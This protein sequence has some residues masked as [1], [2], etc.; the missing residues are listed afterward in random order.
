MRQFTPNILFPLLLVFSLG[1]WISL[2][3]PHTEI[4]FPFETDA[5]PEDTIVK[6]KRKKTQPNYVPEDRMGDPYAN[7]EKSSMQLKDPD[8]IQK[9]VELDPSLEHYNVNEKVGD[10]DYRAPSEVSFEEFYKMKNQEMLKN[11]WKNK[12][13]VE[14]SD[15]PNKEKGPFSL[16][17]PVRGLEGPFGSNFVDIRPTGLV[18]LDFGGKWQRVYNPALTVRQQK[19]GVFDFDQQITMNVVGKIGEK[20]KITANWDTKAAFEFQNNVK[21]QYTAFE[22][23][24]IQG[25]EVGRVS[26][27]LNSTLINGAQ[28]LFGVKTKL[29]FGR[30]T[31][32]S[33]FARQDGKVDEMVI[34]GGSQGR[35]FEVKGHNYEDYRH[36]FLS[37][38]F[39]ENFE[40]SLESL[41]VMNSG[42]KVTRVE[43]YVTN[44]SST[45]TDLRDMISYLDL[46]E[47]R[48]Y[49]AAYTNI[50]PPPPLPTLVPAQNTAN[51]L[52]KD[53]GNFRNSDAIVT[54][55]T[56][57]GLVNGTD[58]ALIKSARKLTDK[59]FTFHPDLGYISLQTPIRSDEVLAVSFEYSYQGK[60]YKVG[61][62]NEDYQGLPA[63][64]VVILKML[65]PYTIKLDLPT[66][67]LMMKNIYNIGATQL[68]RDNFQLRVIYKDD[69]SGVDLPNLQEGV[70]TKDK[71]LLQ[72]MG[73]DRL[74]PNNDPAPDGNFDYVEGVT[75]DSRNGRI[76]FPKLQPFGSNLDSQFTPNEQDLRIKYVF[77]ELYSSTK[78][79]AEQQASRNKFFLKGRYQASSSSEIILPGINIAPGSVVVIVG[80]NQLTEGTDYTI[81]YT[82]GRLKIINEGAL[83]SGQEI[84]IRF[85]KQDLFNFRRKSFYGGRFDYQINKDFVIGGT[86]LQQNEAPQITRVNVGDEPSKNTVWGVD[87][88]YTKDSRIITKAVDKIPFID[89]KAPSNVSFQGE[90]AQML[91]GHNKRI[92]QDGSDGV[93]FIDDFEGSK[94]PYDVSK[95]PTKWKLAATPRRFIESDSNSLA[96]SYRKA[97]FAWYNI[98]NV[99]YRNNNGISGYD[100]PS[101][102][103]NHFER[104]IFPQE[105]Y[106]NQD[107]QQVNINLTTFDLSF[108][109][110]ERGPYNF[111]PNLNSN[112]RL[113]NPTQNWGGVSRNITSDIDFDNANIQYIEFWMM[114]PY[115]NFPNPPSNVANTQIEGIPFNQTNKGKL[116]FNLGDISEDIMNDGKQSYENGLPISEALVASESEETTWGRVSKKQFL[117]DAFNN[118]PEARSKQDVGLDG[119]GNSGETSFF[120]NYVQSIQ[121]SPINPTVKDSILKD[122][123]ADDFKYYLGDDQNGKNIVQRYKNF[124]GVDNNSPVNSGGSFTPSNSSLPDNEDLN[125][126][127]TINSLEEYYEYEVNIDPTKFLVGQ[128]FIVSTRDS[129]I[130]G[131][132]VTWYQFRIPVRSPTST[133]GNIDGYKSI[134]FMRMYMSGFTSPIILRTA[135]MQLVANQWRGYQSDDINESG[136]GN[137]AEPDDALIDVST[138]NVEENGQGDNATSPYVVPPGFSRDQDVTSTVNRRL[139]EQSLRLCVTDLDD[140]NARAVYKNVSY[141]FMNYGKVNMFI[142][143]ES[144]DP[145]LTDGKVSAFLRL[146]TDFKDNYYEI[147]VPLYLTNPKNTN[148]PNLI[149]R[150]ENTI[151][152]AITELVNTKLE[153]DRAGTPVTG[154]YSRIFEGKKLTVVGKP[155]LSAVVTIMIGLKNPG[156]DNMPHSFC[157]WANELRVTD[158]NEKSGWAATGKLNVKLADFGNVTA[159]GRFIGAGFGSLEQKVSQRQR[160]NLLEWG[161]AGNFSLDKFLPKKIGLKLPMYVGYNR[162]V[163]TPRYDPLSPD[164]LLKDRLDNL[165]SGTSQ[166]EYKNLVLDQSTT[167]AI[168]FT[169]IQKVKTN[170]SSK[171]HIYDVENLKLTLGYTQT[172]RTSY[173][174]KDY[175]FKYYKVG[176]GYD[177]TG[178]PK[179]Y[180]PFK[181]SEIFKSKY[182]KLIKD[183]NFTPLPNLFTFR[184][185]F[186]RKTTKSEYYQS[187]PLSGTQP[188]LYEK[189]FTIDRVYGTSWN[190]T[191]SI[192]INYRAKSFSMVDEPLGEPGGKA[193]NQTMYNNMFAHGFGRLKN[194]DQMT[195]INYKL[196]LDKIPFL[197]WTN[198]DYRY[199]AGY[200][201]TSGALGIRDTLGNIVQNTR[202]QTINSKIDLNKLY[203][204]NKFL[205]GVNNPS[206]K[207]QNGKTEGKVKSNEEAKKGADSTEKVKKDNKVL[208]AALRTVMLIK[209]VNLT[210]NIAEGTQLTGYL[211]KPSLFGIDDI[212]NTGTL[213]PFIMGS[214][215]PDIRHEA[216][217]NGWI[218]KS[219]ALN[220]PFT[221]FRNQ[222]INARTS[223]EPTKDLR[224][225]LDAMVKKG[226]TYQELFRVDSIGDDYVSDNPLRSGNYSISTITFL[227]AFKGKDAGSSDP[228]SSATYNQFDANRA[229]IGQRL[230]TSNLKSQ[231]VM[232]PAFL[233]AYKGQSASSI[234]LTNMPKIPL[235][236]WRIDFTGLTKLSA[237]KRNFESI[238]ISH[239]YTSVYNVGSYTSSLQ[240]NSNYVKPGRDFLSNTPAGDSLNSTGDVIPVYIIN[241]VNIRESFSPL[242]GLNIRT[243][244]KWTYRIEYRRSRNLS[245]SLTN[246]QMRD[247]KSQD[248]VFGIGYLKSGVPI[249]KIF[250]RGKKKT[251]KNEL[252]VRL[253]FTIRDTKG[254]QR[255]LDESSTVTSGALNWQVKPT[256]TYNLSSRVTL[257]LYF[258]RTF[259]NPKISSSYKRTTTSVGV[260]LRFTLS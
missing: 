18:T 104:T 65:K 124:N 165:P 185:D 198:V 94:T 38:F 204:K 189:S 153:R 171:S 219:R 15:S 39:K 120:K 45:T 61:E 243:K 216:A 57:T 175:T 69:L 148:D 9:D 29:K 122:P 161:V 103:K 98:D 91:P 119:F 133:V 244:G 248:F 85:E 160:N 146:G 197:D 241:E 205:K 172:K 209:A 80:S 157:I 159:T 75:V 14:K 101:T 41:P 107:K 111:T 16:K 218:S 226:T 183:F 44:R 62:M 242:I 255:Q 117:T 141:D 6:K 169:N 231:D 232:I 211:N 132:K 113:L 35:T 150:G 238:T 102:I 151:A 250:T 224:I 49:H 130:N 55:L 237:F 258:E 89:T 125:Q 36:F 142:H 92:N 40:R 235:P 155:D 7:P 21:V 230:G 96:F 27:P 22:E 64:D 184:T 208:K 114:S 253:D 178:S 46:G 129:T 199:A 247:E 179:S 82:L 28:N 188:A 93:A 66:W 87:V 54:N 246:A 100:D 30:M 20:L 200:M 138:V 83:A 71:P 240:Y 26:M 95:S 203:N 256:I 116:Y 225:Q 223:L 42:V 245:L 174:I 128:N 136:V 249:P 88:N 24:I 78:Q 227:T 63:S 1:T 2:A 43:V 13:S 47:A 77:T 112:G 131:D 180:E 51:T 37:H 139:N 154:A 190:L 210:Y 186:D 156:D 173:D 34:Q 251:L 176:L 50:P 11:Y 12:N 19:N 33:V 202:D 105:L 84:R 236:N 59:D 53:V 167:K 168:N 52:L 99:F 109:P 207:R 3:K 195:D 187:G 229:I 4:D 126:D 252:N 97:K 215:N 220:T 191:K 108:Y 58:F 233:A 164:V 163:I 23:D 212:N 162:K 90:F 140:K 166:D 76:V 201:W 48:P 110:D 145:T 8:V 196:P 86:I 214:Q 118:D 221:Q 73:V 228:N 147:E 217:N 115:V 106:P 158:F 134:R 177:F 194:Y 123:S 222:T 81:D 143:G 152:M 254:V 31:V 56:A 257:Q 25:I 239:G 144:N 213:L 32:T 234:N 10:L 121:T 137:A 79:F 74:N 135:N 259:N 17:I 72:I 193:Y 60:I 170:P 127:N 182:S 181:D 5:A 192:T 70:N 149:W 67:D 68:T 260:Q 206:A